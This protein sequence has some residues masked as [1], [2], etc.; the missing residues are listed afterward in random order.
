MTAWADLLD[1]IN[2]YP[3]ADTDTGRNLVIS[4]GPLRRVLDHEWPDTLTD[5]LL[6]SA[7]GNSGNI[8]SRFF[9]GFLSVKS[10]AGLTEACRSGAKH[11]R[12]A[13]GEPRDG[14]MLDVFDALPRAL[15]LGSGSVETRIDQI[16]QDLAKSVERTSQVLPEMKAAGVVD[17]GA[18]GM[19]L[20]FEGF[21][22]SLTEV[23][24]TFPPPTKRFGEKLRLSE[25]FR[26][27]HMA[28]HCVEMVIRPEKNPTEVLDRLR[29]TGDSFVF[30]RE[31]D[32]IRVHLH[33]EKTE[34]LKKKVMSIGEILEWSE[35]KLIGNR[36]KPDFC[37]VSRPMQIVTD[38]AGSLTREDARRLGI[39]LLESYVLTGNDCIPETL[40]KR[41]RIYADL[42]KGRKVTTSQ[43]SAF[44]I[45]L[46]LERITSA[47][48]PTLYLCVGSVY[49]GNYHIALSWKKKNDHHG[50]LT[51]VDTG[52]ASGRLACM[53]MAT[54]EFADRAECPEDISRFVGEI[55]DRAEEYIFPEKLKYLAASGRLT[56]TG[57]FFGDMIGIMPVVSPTAEGAKTVGAAINS[58][59]RLSFAIDKLKKASENGGLSLI[60]L[61]FSDNRVWVQDVVRKRISEMFPETRT[62]VRPISLTSGIHIGPGAWAVA[63]VKDA[64]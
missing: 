57:A 44:E 42:K 52:A 10:T 50:R 37:K 3:V 39:E 23:V 19:F 5:R 51:V 11:A 13:V 17:A 6:F 46:N 31:N 48:K 40:A 8:A 53:A 20:F 61:E 2:V 49:T 24:E 28:G 18:L 29:C 1:R 33:A 38:A 56:K 60:L 9:S 35:E 27:P 43:A 54:A 47:G 26:A 22:G 64:R 14:T 55:G 59:A 63:F 62:L 30:A 21:F 41:P 4:L 36:D 7:K 58:R 15:E 16:V 32:L 12:G 34:A 45:G 25:S